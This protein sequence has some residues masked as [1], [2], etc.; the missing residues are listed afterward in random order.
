MRIPGLQTIMNALSSLLEHPVRSL[1]TSL[2]III[3]VASVYSALSI[4]EG[5]RQ[6][7]LENVNSI[8][9]RTLQLWPD[10]SRRGRSS[11]QR[12]WIPFSEDTLNQIKDLTGVMAVSGT[13][14]RNVTV[15]NENSDWEAEMQAAD[16]DYL[17]ANDLTMESG[18]PL[19]MVDMEQRAT[20]AVIGQTVKKTLFRGEDPVGTRIKL[21]NIPF[22][23]KGVVSDNSL[24]NWR[25]QDNNN[26]ILIPRTTARNRIMGGNAYVRDWVSSFK[27]V[28]YEAGDVARI[29]QATREIVSRERGLAPNAPPDFNIFSS[30]EAR[31]RSANTDRELQFLLNMIGA[32]ALLVGGVGV[33]NIMLVSVTERTREIGLRMAIGAPKNSILSQFLTEAFLLSIFSGIVGLTIGYFTVEAYAKSVTSITTAFSMKIAILAAASA[34]IV[35][36]VFG[37][38]PAFRAAQLNPIEALRHE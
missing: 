17:R 29:E 32:V 30:Q 16:I 28:T 7:I 14:S 5:T 37:F 26:F 19:T 18:E 38:I 3:G 36:V 2:G 25:G 12:A 22:T 1:L 13:M 24:Q 11:Q 10:R 34:P 31:Q 33:M 35:G 20:V 23:I 6:K 21:N 9:A 4:G 27:I 15:V 8:E